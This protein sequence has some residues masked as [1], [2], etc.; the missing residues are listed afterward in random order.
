MFGET[1][2]VNRGLQMKVFDN[3]Q[4]AMKWLLD[5]WCIIWLLA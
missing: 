1:A 3:E 5:T 2:A 4:D